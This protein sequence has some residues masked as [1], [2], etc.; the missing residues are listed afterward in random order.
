MDS[1]I[2]LAGSEAT[3]GAGAA[4]KTPK[5]AFGRQVRRRRA[6]FRPDLRGHRITLAHLIT[7]AIAQSDYEYRSVKTAPVLRVY[8]RRGRAELEVCAPRPFL[9]LLT[10]NP[11][12]DPFRAMRHIVRLSTSGGR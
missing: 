8:R 1:R 4:L 7:S 3:T 11:T 5:V 10:D 2:G 6:T 12:N 9:P